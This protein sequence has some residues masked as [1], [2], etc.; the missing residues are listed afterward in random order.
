MYGLAL[1]LVF[2]AGYFYTKGSMKFWVA[3][4]L[5]F[6]SAG[7]AYKCNYAFGRGEITVLQNAKKIKDELQDL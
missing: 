2:A 3:A 7:V 4:P 6:W 1:G 5:S